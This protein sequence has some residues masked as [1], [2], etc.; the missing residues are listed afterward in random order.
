MIQALHGY[1][2]SVWFNDSYV[3]IYI[4]DYGDG[5]FLVWPRSVL[6]LVDAHLSARGELVAALWLLYCRM[7]LGSSRV[8]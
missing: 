8:R 3:Y 6:L 2:L 1:T 7:L 4:S 5:T